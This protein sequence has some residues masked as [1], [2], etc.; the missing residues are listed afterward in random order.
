MKTKL[1][2]IGA[3]LLSLTPSFGQTTLFYDNFDPVTF[4]ANVTS[5]KGFTASTP[6]SSVSDAKATY[7]GYNSAPDGFYLAS[8]NGTSGINCIWNST[9]STFTT[10]L[11]VQSSSTTTFKGTSTIALPLS[12]ISAP[13][14]PVLKSNTDVITWSF[15]MRINKSTQMTPVYP[16][17][18]TPGLGLAGGIILVTDAS[19]TAPISDAASTANGYAVIFSGSDTGGSTS[20]NRV[21]FGS[22]TSGLRYDSATTSSTFSSLLTVDGI[23]AG[24]N[25]ISVVVTY[26]PSSDT[27]TM[28]V[29]QDLSSSI[30]DPEAITANNY[31]VSKPSS[32]VDP[33][34]TST[35]M[36]NMMLFYNHNATN[37][38]YVDHLRIK[39]N[40]ILGLSKNE[41]AG[42]NVYPNP[43]TNGQLFISSNS[44]S[45]KQ[46]AIYNVL[47]QKMLQTKTNN[48]SEINVSQ[49]AK[50]AYILN[51]SEDGKSESKKL[52]I[53]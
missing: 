13:Y 30:A 28:K 7:T 18:I 38:I 8:S 1:L 16:R 52:I 45:E 3:L 34:Y 14:T 19:S 44:S 47:G 50:G 53:Q 31:E 46:V 17:G 24:G 49:L 9:S 32:R 37:G 35:T 2:F 26:T 51:I 36:T 33:L 39:T 48:N 42:L 6:T 27:W 41:I 29:R 43:V 11:S 10:N 12:S 20:I 23:A 21:D 4:P 15:G 22:F 5:N 25:A 40:A